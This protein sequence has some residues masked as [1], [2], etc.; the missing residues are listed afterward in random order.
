M[1]ERTEAKE[2]RQKCIYRVT[3]RDRR[4]PSSSHFKTGAFN[5]SATHPCYDFSGL[6]TLGEQQNRNCNPLATGGAISSFSR[7][8]KYP[9]D[10]FRSCRVPTL[11]HMTVDIQPDAGLGVPQA[12]ANGQHVNSGADEMKHGMSEGMKRNWR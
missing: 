4:K 7:R 2:I 8:S 11:K 10:S 3:R 1:N 12:T 9:G 6:V 5:H